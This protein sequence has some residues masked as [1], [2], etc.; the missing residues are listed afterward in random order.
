MVAHGT[1]VQTSV[2]GHWG[3][4]DRLRPEP[5]S[6]APSRVTPLYVSVFYQFFIMKLTPALSVYLPLSLECSLSG[7]I[8]QLLLPT[9]PKRVAQV[10]FACESGSSAVLRC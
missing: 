4:F 7:L 10:I 1:L 5:I 8:T 9:R 2:W 3:V 6:G